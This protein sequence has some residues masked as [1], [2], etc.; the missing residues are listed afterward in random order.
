MKVSFIYHPFQ[1]VKNQPNIE[2]VSENYGVFPPLNLAYVA[3]IAEKAGHDVQLIDANALNLTKE[4]TLREIKRF[5][6]DLLAFTITSYLFHQTRDWISY[7]KKETGL[8]TLIG[9]VNNSLYPKETLSHKEIDFEVIGEA[10]ETLPELLN[11]F[12]S[13]NLKKIKGL[14]YKNKDKIILNAQRRP[15]RD[16]NNLPLPA[17]H[18]LPNNKYYSFISQRKNFTGLITTRGC[19]YKCIFCEQGNKTYRERPVKEV[20]KEIEECY[21]K[22]AIREIDV[23]DPSFTIRKNRAIEI[24]KGI[25]DLKI[26]LY[27]AIRTRADKVDKELLKELANAGC[28]RIYYGI[29]SGN[30]NI[31]KNIK[32][33]TNL[34]IIKK[35]INLTKKEGIDTF[36]YFIIGNPGETKETIRETINFSKK[37]NLDYAQFSK[38]S[39]L[40]GTELYELLKK[41]MGYDYWREYLLDSSKEKDLPKYECNLSEGEIQD[42][43][44]KA[45]R[46][47]YFRP[48]R[49]IKILLKIRSFDEFKR[50]IKAGLRMVF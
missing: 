18:L 49:I 25:K 34:N 3:A 16:L 42:L 31:L 45:Y 32:K 13:D 14:A 10:E 39:T 11:S 4:Q 30:E 8:K 38:I 23:F 20:I 43:V 41:Q 50:Y 17:R 33:T 47:F 36:G 1:S 7:L 40:P 21:Y 5:N 15:L 19:P 35:T 48:G 29:E 37:L 12:Q 2:A 27:W 6:P 44:N 22:H 9:G 46:E 26:G 24:C 28:K